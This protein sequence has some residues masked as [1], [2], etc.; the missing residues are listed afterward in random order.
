MNSDTGDPASFAQ[1]L[2]EVL[3]T[4]TIDRKGCG[5]TLL[6]S[7]SQERQGRH[8]RRTSKQSSTCKHISS[9]EESSTF[10]LKRLSQITRFLEKKKAPRNI[11][12]GL[13]VGRLLF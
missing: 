4:S 5:W 11:A 3:V 10:D 6:I 7:D 13:R 8:K 2:D 9:Q 1:E 12:Q